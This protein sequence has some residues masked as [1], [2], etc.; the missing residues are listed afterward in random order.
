MP[1][2][3]GICLYLVAFDSPSPGRRCIAVGYGTLFGCLLAALSASLLARSDTAH[4][5]RAGTPWL[6]AFA[7]VAALLWYRMRFRRSAPR[8]TASGIEQQM[9][10][11]ASPQHFLWKPWL[12]IALLGSLAA[13]ALVIARE[14]ALRPLYPWDAWS[15]WAVKPKT[16]VLLGHYVPFGS[17]REW[18]A[19]PIG[20]DLRTFAAWTYPDALAWLDV[21]FASA[22][23]GWIEPLINM[24]WLAVWVAILLA[25]YGQWRA[26][27]LSRARAVLAVYVLGSLPLLTVHAAVAGYA[28]LW[29]AALFGFTV[30]AWMRWLHGQ[31]RRQLVLAAIC[32]ATLP[33]I[34]VEG[35]V[36]AAALFLSMGF[37]A[38]SPRWRLRGLAA[39]L[40]AV[41]AL[42]FGGLH[43]LV[44]L[45][46]WLDANGNVLEERAGPFA[47]LLRLSWHG[48][49]LTGAEYALLALPSWNLFW[50]IVPLVVVWRWRE[51]VV[52]D[53][54]RLPALLLLGCFAAL[55]FLFLATPAA[56][57]AQN[58]TAIN[59]LV[60][61][62][63]PAACSVLALLVPDAA[64]PA[65]AIDTA[66]VPAAH[67]DPA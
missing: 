58:F 7:I 22:A 13:R 39:V 54:L 44:S 12:L 31:E 26:L 59:R 52:R 2:L 23:G 27:G 35:W 29:I 33:F 51:L 17:I 40:V 9:S 3:A 43:Y 10:L 38:L 63:T 57:W 49:A 21:W 36:W 66:R 14:I 48:D 11:R 32:A 1:L 37:G 30:L 61:Q 65:R 45:L 46:G 20:Q 28:D 42:F 34:K 41:A 55:M 67:T 47:E 18:A 50:W 56:D 24:P 60:L 6:L 15:T 19:N 62:L 53:W 4:A 8:A 64:L 25:H 16:W 5:W